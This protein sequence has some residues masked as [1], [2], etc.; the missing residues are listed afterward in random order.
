MPIG[1]GQSILVVDD[2]QSIASVAAR[3]L[4]GF[5]YNAVAVSSSQAALETLARQPDRFRLLLTDYTMPTMNGV[6]LTRKIHEI[7]PR[8]P[9]VLMSGAA[10][11]WNKNLALEA[12]FIGFL[13][14]PFTA[15]ELGA[16]VQRCLRLAD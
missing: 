7:R 5:N 3:V 1:S 14:K 13:A 12:E 8:F 6:E 2:E 10:D 4:N 11:R 9:C 16:T 15:R